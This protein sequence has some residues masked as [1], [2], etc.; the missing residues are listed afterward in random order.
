MSDNSSGGNTG[1]ENTGNAGTES[2]GN[3]GTGNTG[4]QQ[5]VLNYMLS[6]KVEAGLWLTRVF[7]VVCTVLFFFP[8]IGDNPYGFYQRVFISSAA[9]S[10]LRLHQRLPHIQFSRQFMGMLFAEDSCH[11]LIFSL[12]FMN[13]YPITMALIPVFLF[14]L[15]HACSYTK[16][17]LN[18]M[19][20][21]SM[22]IIRSLIDKLTQQQIN[23]LRFI[24]CTEIF[25][26][27]AVFFMIFVGKCSIFLPAIYYRFLTL[28][29]ASRRNPY[30]RT[31]FSE[32]RMTIEHFISR[33]Q[34][35]GFLRNALTKGI[36]LIS[37]LA[38]QVAH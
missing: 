18:V 7:T 15:L 28:R 31:L 6:N 24:A 26:M 8:I 22:Q 36:A 10:A 25:L 37:R 35:P 16:N 5:T 11:Y 2:T 4:N 19:G 32:L 9:T 21:Q 13:S 30:C 34:C 3:A 38:P 23:I 17:L 33:P 12:I 29:Y 1:A 14:A 27:P 20:P